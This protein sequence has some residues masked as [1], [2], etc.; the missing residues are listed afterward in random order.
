MTKFLKNNKTLANA[1]FAILKNRETQV[2]TDNAGREQEQEQ[3]FNNVTSGYTN[4]LLQR[5]K[6]KVEDEKIFIVERL[7]HN[8]FL[9]GK[10][11]GLEIIDRP[12][13]SYISG[14]FEPNGE[15]SSLTFT[16]HAKRY[17]DKN[18]TCSLLK[19]YVYKN[20]MIKYTKALII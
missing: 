18:K 6:E 13:Y 4:I 12:N 3:D 9:I 2:S 10:N 19:K 14:T 1:I 7:N 11:V 8:D 17:T 5:V 15:D 20:I 16:D